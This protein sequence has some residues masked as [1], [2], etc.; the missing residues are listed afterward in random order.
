MALLDGANPTVTRAR[1]AKLPNNVSRV[2]DNPNLLPRTSSSPNAVDDATASPLNSPYP[3][4]LRNEADGI[5]GGADTRSGGQLRVMCGP[6]LNYHGMTEEGSQ[7]IWHGSVLL[8]VE[9]GPQIPHL[10]LLSRGPI[11]QSNPPKST[12]FF[13]EGEKATSADGL[14]LYQDPFKTFWRFT[15]RL[16]L[17]TSE[18]R[19][20]YSIP[21]MQFRSDAS[22]NPSRE[23]VVPAVSQS[24]RLMFHSCNGFSVGTDEDH[25]SGE[26][27]FHSRMLK[28]HNPDA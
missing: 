10:K 8:V 15:L 18:T 2:A 4:T 11:A 26:A 13:P 7:T 9:P 25:W 20:E 3:S 14:K 22:A 23:F 5:D 17:D 19:W 1:E 16:P 21:G 6:L 28:N 24:M 12:G 27:N